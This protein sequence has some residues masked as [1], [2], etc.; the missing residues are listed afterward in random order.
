[1]TPGELNNILV[2]MVEDVVSH[3]LPNGKRE[4][5]EWCC[6]DVTGS[7][8]RSMKVKLSGNRAGL[9]SDFAD[10]G[11]G[12]DLLELWKEAR[13]ISF[14]DAMKEAADF[15]GVDLVPYKFANKKIY[16][17]P[18]K[19]KDIKRASTDLEEWFVGRGITT[20]T[21]EFFKIAQSK[22]DIV[23]PY[24]SPN[25]DLE[26]LKYRNMKE[27]KFFSSAG[28][29]P[30]LFGWQA[31]SDDDR[32]VIL[33]EGELDAMTVRQCGHASLSVPIGGGKGNK[34]QWIEYEYDR[35]ERFDVIYLCLDTD[36]VGVAATNEIAERLGRHR[37]KL[38]EL[39]KKDAN[40][41]LMSGITFDFGEACRCAKS[42]DPP[43]LKKLKDFE[44]EIME[45]FNLPDEQKGM[46]LPWKKTY[47]T[48]RLR[49]GEVSIWAGINSHGKSL[50]LSHVVVDGVSQGH[51]FCMASME[52]PPKR[53]GKKMFQQITSVGL[54]SAKYGAKAAEFMGESIFV[55]NGYGRQKASKILGVFEY[56]RKKYG[57]DHFVIDSLAKCGFA[58]DDYNGQKQYVEEVC[59]FALMHNVHVHIVVHIKK[60]ENED[61]VPG[62][63]D[64][65]GTGAITDMA[66]NCFLV[67]RNK[68][69]EQKIK[70]GKADENMLM[71]PDQIINCV[72]QRDT[73]V[74]PII[75]LSFHPQSCQYTESQDA[76]PKKYVF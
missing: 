73:G 32:E 16:I 74:E 36:K 68:K 76:T 11:K 28:T 43:E 58:E 12:G 64:V 10:G 27:K 17:N 65:K 34:Q 15:S 71:K 42:L 54:P 49:G 30:C 5:D 55:Y 37:C 63:F 60:L 2:G 35:L 45:E 66:D 25:G 33:T 40:E 46:K 6:G 8:G 72:K 48:I 38:I 53:L 31:I 39:P 7:P 1:M 57:V 19:P 50:A 41:V 69:K 75:Y 56:A 70:E 4:R 67:W 22:N 9:W 47:G 51:K 20:D 21:I 29:A 14:K 23:F 62:K 3:L 18:E 24:I 59:E 61:K 52:M 13:N 26:H 44:S